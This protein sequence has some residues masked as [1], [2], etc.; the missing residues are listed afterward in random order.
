MDKK[1]VLKSYN[2]PPV[3]PPNVVRVNTTAGRII[4]ELQRETGLTA[5]CIVSQIIIQARDMIECSTEE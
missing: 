3:Q 4:R 5:S 1:I 2:V